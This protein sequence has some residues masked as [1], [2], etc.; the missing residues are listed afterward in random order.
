MTTPTTGIRPIIPGFHPDPSVCR[1][2]EDYYIANSSFEFSP[3]VPLWHSRDLQR[4]ELIGNILTR[5]DQFEPGHAAASQGVYAPTLRHHDGR[6][7]LITT[8]VSGG[9]G[10]LLVTATDPRGP[11]SA[12]VT[13]PGLVG[14]DPDIA[15]TDDG[16]C[17]VTYCATTPELHGIAQARIDPRTG[18]VLDPPRAMWSG[19]G[20]SFPEAP[21]LYHRGPWWYL[22]IAEGGTER[23]HAVSVARA[24]DPRGPFEG[25]PSNPIL[26]HRSTPHPVQSTGH[27]DLVERA[28]GSWAMVYLAVRPRGTTPQFHVNGRET[29]LADVVWEDD[30]PI[31]YERGQ[32]PDA[33]PTSFRETFEG[34]VVP[35]RFVS[36]GSA[37]DAFST[38]VADG[39]RMLRT[40]VATGGNV[41]LLSVR[42]AD[43]RWRASAD[44]GRD[45]GAIALRVRLDEE[46]WCEVR[47]DA[48]TAS[49]WMRVGP[50]EAR[51]GTETPLA[52][53]P[54]TLIA[55]AVEPTF[56]GPDDLRLLVRAGEDEIE[57]ARVDGR[58]LST[59]VA[60]GFTGRVVGVRAVEGA[61]VLTA[62]EYEGRDAR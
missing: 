16:E 18:A 5:P 8:D 19:T 48:A 43:E 56:G 41:S 44:V 49:A 26:S 53:S 60:G 40:D 29:F 24:A 32:S 14:I 1:V 38:R 21:H 6:F 3:G 55:E 17:V 57:L 12:P 46:H 31:V 37:I 52:A 34:H 35:P 22:V 20:L 13:I 2:G 9:G 54:V 27:A 50:L 47:A 59:E 61:P 28:D 42:T 15:W 39:G 4:W 45:G 10:Q 33:A 7:W 11:W 36:P 30:W 51:V 62:L 58:Y 23:G 25:A